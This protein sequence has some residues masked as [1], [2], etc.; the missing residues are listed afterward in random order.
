MNIKEQFL[1]RYRR[2][3]DFY[4]QAARLGAQLLEQQLQ[5]AGIRVIVTARAKSLSRLEEKIG[6]RDAVKQ[7]KSVEDVISDIVDLAGIRIALYFPGERDQVERVVSNIFA[8]EGTKPKVFPESSKKLPKSKRF[9]GY[10]AIHFRVRL[11]EATLN[12]TQKRYALAQIE[13]Q[14]ASVLM[15]AWAE[16]EHD[17]IYK[18]LQ[19]ALSDAEYAIL[20]Q[21]NGLVIAG[22]I[23]LEQLQSAGNQRIA[24][25]G[26]S[27]ASHYDLAAYLLDQTSGALHSENSDALL[28]RINVLYRMLSKLDSA[29]PEGLQPYLENIS[30]DFERRPLADQIIDRMLAEDPARYEAYENARAHELG[31]QTTSDYKGQETD[32]EQATGRFLARWI[33]LEKKLRSIAPNTKRWLVPST[34]FITDILR[35]DSRR[36]AEFDYVRRFRNNLVHG[37][38][39][40]TASDIN[41]A[42]QVLDTILQDM[43]GRAET[44]LS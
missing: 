3:F 4:D 28:G 44:S 27:F 15:H 35:Y 24:D 34:S 18:P 9:S 33:E 1:E 17:L 29:S 2:E 22:E 19:G 10:S 39:T 5:N 21:I 37:V 41:A 43:E 11:R 38:E 23:A 25:Q 42:T 6:Q 13:I 8:T 20:D 26:R 36:A 14:I 32:Q 16:V 31:L 40:P 7:Y 30:T 12:E